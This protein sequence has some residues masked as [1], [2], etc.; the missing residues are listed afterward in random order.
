MRV[1]TFE[2]ITDSRFCDNP[3]ELLRDRK[4][5][6]ISKLSNLPGITVKHEVER[7]IDWPDTSSEQ[8]RCRFFVEK[9]GRKITWNDIYRVI[10]SV[11]PAMYK[12]L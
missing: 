3:A 10:N 11:H 2:Q 5:A 6:I 8:Y 12:F 1:L 4:R 9:S 7:H